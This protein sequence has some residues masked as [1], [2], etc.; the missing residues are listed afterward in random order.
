VLTVELPYSSN[1]AER[2]WMRESIREGCPRKSVESF[3]S[4]DED[5]NLLTL[6]EFGQ[7]ENVQPRD[8]GRG[9]NASFG[10]LL[11][12]PEGQEIGFKIPDFSTF[13][14]EDSDVAEIW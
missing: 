1:E 3:L 2:Y 11:R 9:A 14:P 8:H 6:I 7:V 10:Y 12:Y 13:D 5:L 4:Y